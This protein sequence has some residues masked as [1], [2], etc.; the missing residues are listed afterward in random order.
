MVTID[1][2]HSV[3]DAHLARMKLEGSGVH[4]FLADDA[5]IGINWAYSFAIGGVR[6]QVRNEDQ[7]RALEVLNLSPSEEGIIS[8]PK[9]GSQNINF[10]KITIPWALIGLGVLIPIPSSK[11]NCL[12]CHNVFKCEIPD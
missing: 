10:R 12:D 4:V 3:D 6:L 8:C 11:I 7:A 1:K 5:M 2:Y 9:C